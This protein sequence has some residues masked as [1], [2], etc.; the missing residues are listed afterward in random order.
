MTLRTNQ[1]GVD[2]IRSC[3]GL[4]LEAYPDPGT[5]GAPW[6][7]GYGHT[8]RDVSPGM[9]IDEETAEAFLL[10]DI[11]RAEAG[12]CDLVNVD[13]TGNQLSAL[14][15]FAYNVGVGRLQSSTL[16]RMVNAGDVAGAAGQ[17]QRWTR[18]NGRE[19]PG[20]VARRAAERALFDTPGDGTPID[21]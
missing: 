17:F 21:A 3:E 10:G 9:T 19:M 14:V 20:L 4:R 1:E 2:L 18:A 12:V 13:L 6:T 5:G 7:I 8:G 15:S 16:L 11:G